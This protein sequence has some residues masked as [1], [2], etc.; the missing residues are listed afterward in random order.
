[1]AALAGIRLLRPFEALEA[2]IRPFEAARGRL[3]LIRPLGP[4]MAALAG[5]RPL[6]PLEALEVEIR[7]FEAAR[8]HL[9]QDKAA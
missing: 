3:G 5:I 4:L 2:E 7:P 6:R 8:G 9:G 1:M